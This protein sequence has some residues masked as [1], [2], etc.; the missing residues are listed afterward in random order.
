[1]TC[2]TADPLLHV[3]TVIEENKIR[4]LIY[5]RPVQWLL[6]GQAMTN[7]CKHWR[8]HP[9]L[10]M[11]THTGVRRRDSGKRRSLHRAMAIS[12]I[13]PQPGNVV[14][15]A[16][17]DLLHPRHALLRC[18]WRPV[19]SIN[20]SPGTKKNNDARAQCHTRDGIAAFAKNLS[21]VA[22]F[23][24]PSTRDSALYEPCIGVTRL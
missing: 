9:Y 13:N 7:R 14:L 10:R 4:Q 22:A 11:A 23:R 1:M 2:G 24:N 6:S 3:N 12:A 18:I 5:S 20:Q 16:E 8:V 21:H 19:N 17:R 15:M